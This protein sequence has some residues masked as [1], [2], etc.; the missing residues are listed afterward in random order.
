VTLS[1]KP[2]ST[3]ER[4]EDPRAGQNYT[5]SL[6]DAF[7]SKTSR[8]FQVVSGEFQVL[9]GALFF[10][11][12]SFLFLGGAYVMWP[13]DFFSTPFAQMTFGM[14]LRSVASPVLAII[15]LEFFGSLAIV[16]L[17]DR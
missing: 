13:S 3:S 15:G 2:L 17:S 4:S 1:L 12:I 6:F 9:A 8:V 11:A 5:E 7:L 16:T 14:L 10:A